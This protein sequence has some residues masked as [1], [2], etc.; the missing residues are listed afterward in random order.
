ML[1][2]LAPAKINLGLHVLRKR[3]DGFHDIETVFAPIGWS[4]RL[5]WHP[6]DLF[7]FT[8]DDPSLPTDEGNLC[9]Q[10]VRRFEEAADLTM[11]GRLHLEKLVPYGA[12]LGSGSSDAAATLQLMNEAAGHS[13]DRETLHA[14]AADIGSDVPFFLQRGWAYGTGRGTQLEVL[15]CRPTAAVGFI[16]VAVPPV[17]VSTPAAYSWVQ[18]GDDD[19]ADLVQ[20]VCKEEPADWTERLVNDF[21]QPVADQ[22]P[23]VADVLRRLRETE[24]EYVSLSGSGAASFALYRSEERA[25]AAMSALESL[26]A[27]LW[28][29]PLGP[30]TG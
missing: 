8:C 27:R 6:G 25:R 13:L 1:T 9:V 11:R 24:A 19:R 5:E 28:F 3:P 10:A 29:G 20:L 21:E 14:L 15:D 17:E 2:T 7:A 22:V 23:E 4:D 26:E 16:V 12:G 30:P 18:P